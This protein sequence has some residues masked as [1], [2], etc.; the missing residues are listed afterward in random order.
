M[1]NQDRTTW[2]TYNNTA[3]GEAMELF[4]SFPRWVRDELNEIATNPD[5]MFG[6]LHALRFGDVRDKLRRLK[7]EDRQWHR[8]AFSCTIEP[9]GNYR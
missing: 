5:D 8:D 2:T 7:D 1:S 4:D 9:R 6:V 3:E